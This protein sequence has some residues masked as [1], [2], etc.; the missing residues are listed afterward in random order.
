M[1]IAQ[2]SPVFESVPPSLYGG[3]ERIVSY[4]TEELV[5]MGHDITLY[6]SADSKTKAE[7]RPVC[8]KAS[9][10]AKVS[11][12]AYNSYVLEK[13][14]Q[15][16]DNFDILHSHL[17]YVGFPAMRRAK[18]PN[19]TT[20][21]GRL[22]IFPQVFNEFNELS[23]VSI[24][25]AQRTPL[26]NANW[27]GMVYHGLPKDLYNFNDKPDNYLAFV[28]R[29]CPEKRVDSAIQ[30]AKM[31]SA[32]LK[33]AAKVDTI[34]KEYFEDIVKPM[35][36]QPGIEFIGEVND[37]KK[38]ELLGNAMAMLFPIEWPEPFGLAIIE[39]LACGT[40]TIAYPYGAIPEIVQNGRTGFIANGMDDA[41]RAVARLPELS[42]VECREVFDKKFTAERMA[43]DYVK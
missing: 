26:P 37:K 6:A 22:D 43:K 24:S 30:I 11:P 32:P 25:H 36:D 41:A 31:A 38:Q 19:I 15:E 13:I 7:L 29:I 4:L 34:D 9:R 16:G 27:K 8:P 18:T 21:H 1:K 17:E 42:R 2:L 23:F 39:A 28:G 14:F 33:I 3:T 12:H 40:P 35:L 20:L 10:L 5:I